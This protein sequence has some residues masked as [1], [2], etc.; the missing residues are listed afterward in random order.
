ME[1]RAARLELGDGTVLRAERVTVAPRGR[2]V[3]AVD[4]RLSRCP[5]SPPP[6][7][8]TARAVRLDPDG[9]LHLRAPVLRLGGVPV[10]WLPALWLRTGR[11]PGLLPPRLEWRGDEGLLAGVDGT[12]PI[13]PLDVDLGVAA[14][15][16][17][18]AELRAR[19]AEARGLDARVTARTD[20]VLSRGRL[21]QTGLS[22]RW[23]LA[24]VQGLRSRAAADVA[25]ATLRPRPLDAW[26]TAAG[27][28]L[29][30]AA[31]IQARQ[32]EDAGEGEGQGARLAGAFPSLAAWTPPLI[33]AP[34]LFATADVHA[35]RRLQTDTLRAALSARTIAA[36][37]LGPLRV[38]AALAGRATGARGPAI[39]ETTATQVAGGAS[40]AITLPLVRRWGTIDHE[41]EPRVAISWTELAVDRGPRVSW[42]DDPET[43][44]PGLRAEASV[45]S[46]WRTMDGAEPAR[47]EA[48]V[49]GGTR[50]L[51]VAFAEARVAA[52]HA[53]LDGQLALDLATG[54]PSSWVDAEVDIGPLALGGGHAHLDRGRSA[55]TD[56]RPRVGE[57]AVAP[58]PAG[59]AELALVRAQLALGRIATLEG[60][61]FA[62][63]D[64]RAVVA[65]DASLV[66]HARCGCLTLGLGAA[67]WRG[68]ELPEVRAIVSVP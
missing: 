20:G 62:D 41:I 9:D 11:R 66:H 28:F 22:A 54:A 15:T 14:R 44:A 12:L 64:A 68:R 7:S 6:W 58:L 65:A 3:R 23:D 19:V 18:P 52:G 60:R 38:T 42:L 5:C 1:L 40:V 16:A 29:G 26:A 45:S 39:G 56:A 2:T 32:S 35:E 59:V 48:G 43:V 49:L 31:G 21:D 36:V 24:S 50:E 34:H 25:E 13:G 63:L 57:L 47:L 10:F 4:V 30:V 27:P 37:P 67:I 61:A 53:R 33:L 8:V 17:G 51:R 46:R 55:W